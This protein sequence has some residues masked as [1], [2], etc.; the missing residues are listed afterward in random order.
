MQTHS[1][2]DEHTYKNKTRVKNGFSFLHWKL[3]YFTQVSE[4]QGD[5]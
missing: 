1:R 4:K 2:I 3:N 5:A